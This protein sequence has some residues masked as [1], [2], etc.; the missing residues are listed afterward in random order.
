LRSGYSADRA[1][2]QEVTGLRHLDRV[3]RA[4]VAVSGGADSVFLLYAL[5]EPGLAAAVLHVNHQLR[6]GESDRDEAFVR[7]LAARLGVPIHVLNA[8]VPAGN[9]EQEAR[10]VRYA[11]FAE[12]LAAGVCDVVATGHTL[13]DQAETVLARFLRG[14]GTA[15][16][17]GI[18]PVTDAGMVRPLLGMRRAEIRDWLTARGILWQEDCSNGDKGFLRNRLRLD[19][20]PQLLELNPSLP[21]VLAGT[22]EWAQAE[23]SYW[24]GEMERL[25]PVHL[26]R[27]AE[28][29]L[30]ETGTF[31][32]LPVAVQRRLLRRGI[33]MVRGS[34]RGVDFGHVEAIRGLMSLAEGS[35]RTQLPDLDIYRSFDWLRLAPVGH[36]TRLERNFQTALAA[37]G[38]T[39]IPERL[40][41][42]DVE[43]ATLPHVY[44][45]QVSALDFAKCAGSLVLRNWRPGD[46]LNSKKIKTLFQEHRIPLW[47][48]R[49]WPVIALGERIVW[50]RQFGSASDFAA[51]SDSHERLVVTERGESKGVAQTSV[52][53][54]G[55]EL[56]RAESRLDARS[57]MRS[58]EA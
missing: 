54:A 42:I 10:R 35:G 57:G 3:R 47:E 27:D 6:G 30:I 38:R 37:P 26:R 51:G 50:T 32:G 9:L 33:E 55:R 28:A 13:D 39:A 53:V 45:E 52:T 31:G 24:A 43:L 41:T 11:F 4:G 14:S 12:C 46:R 15:G 7:D 22:A 58:A 8:P 17:S 34:L 48:R 40:L 29:V 2:I 44:N 5:Y 49:H 36:D 20:M 18:Q 23:E 25:G 19:V 16:L 21:E 1:A 56:Q